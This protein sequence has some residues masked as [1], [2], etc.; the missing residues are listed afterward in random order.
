MT[1]TF[2]VRKFVFFAFTKAINKKVHLSLICE[3][4]TSQHKH[5]TTRISLPA[6]HQGSVKVSSKAK[7]LG[8][9]ELTPQKQL[10]MKILDNSNHAYT[11]EVIPILW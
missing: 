6:T 7:C 5:F 1:S 2:V 11:R 8:C 4:T 9:F 3:P 10:F